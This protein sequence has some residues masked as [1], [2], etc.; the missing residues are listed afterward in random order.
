MPTATPIREEDDILLQYAADACFRAFSEVV[1]SHPYYRGGA[2]LPGSDEHTAAVFRLAHQY[3]T[4]SVAN[5]LRELPPSDQMKW[6]IF[7]VTSGFGRTLGNLIAMNPGGINLP[8]MIG[9]LYLEIDTGRRDA[10][11]IMTPKGRA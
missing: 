11:Q 7:A 1:S 5:A 6:T 9:A 10:E 4:Q 3:M 8:A 2:H